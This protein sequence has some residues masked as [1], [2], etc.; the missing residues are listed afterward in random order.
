MSEHERPI[1]PARATAATTAA[2][3]V[4]RHLPLPLYLRLALGAAA[5]AALALVYGMYLEPLF[6][7]ELA[8]RIWACF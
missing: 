3:Q 7:L 4:P 8:D 5:A 1:I 6:M 2:G